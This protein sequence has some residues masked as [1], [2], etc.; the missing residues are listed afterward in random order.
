MPDL[1]QGG[2]LRYRTWRR[3]EMESYLFCKPAIVRLIMSKNPDIDEENASEHF[4][5]LLR[6]IGLVYPV[7][8]KVSEKSLSNGRLFGSDAKEILYPICDHFGINKYEIAKEMHA[9]EIYD[10]V[11]TLIDEIIAMCA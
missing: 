9:D 10:D 3:W 4:D 1:I 6:L 5:N 11:R 8:Y 2:G 7:D